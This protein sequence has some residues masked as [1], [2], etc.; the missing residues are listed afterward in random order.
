MTHWFYLIG[1]LLSIVGTAIIDW[2]YHLAFWHDRRRTLL[3]VSIGT[4]VFAAWDLVAIGLGIFIHDNGR[5][6]LALANAHIFPP[7]EIVFLLLLCY[8]TLVIYRGTA[9]TWART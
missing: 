2:R 5:F 7:E 9:R 6:N 4:I 3:T 8:S 1:L